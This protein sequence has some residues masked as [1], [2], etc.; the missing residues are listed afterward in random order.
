MA[1]RLGENVCSLVLRG[2]ILQLDRSILY[3]LSNEVAMYLNMFGMLVEHWILGK[4]D[5][6]LIVT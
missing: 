6:P 3:K 1:Q 5:H 2:T 4:F